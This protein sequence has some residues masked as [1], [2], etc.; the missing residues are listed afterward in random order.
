MRW[1]SD[2]CGVFEGLLL[3]GAMPLC[4]LSVSEEVVVP[5]AVA[6]GGESTHRGA[7]VKGY[8]QNPSRPQAEVKRGRACWT[9]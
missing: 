8:F 1:F 3:C 5:L 4:G 7:C 6:I 9:V 2:L